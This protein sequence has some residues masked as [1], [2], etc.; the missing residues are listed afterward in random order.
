[1]MINSPYMAIVTYMAIRAVK[2]YC[3]SRDKSLTQ[4]VFLTNEICPYMVVFLNGSAL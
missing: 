1:M 2:H 3:Q 4:R